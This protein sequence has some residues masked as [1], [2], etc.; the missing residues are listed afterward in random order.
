MYYITVDE[1]LD[2]CVQILE[3]YTLIYQQGGATT[4]LSLHERNRNVQL[5]CLLVEGITHVHQVSLL[6]AVK[7]NIHCHIHYDV[8][9]SIH[10]SIHSSIHYS[11]TRHDVI[12]VLFCVSGY[13]L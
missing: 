7:H 6:Y 10:N 1:V 12:K 5:V 9:F 8:C 11:M 2:S 4:N 13:G 3:A